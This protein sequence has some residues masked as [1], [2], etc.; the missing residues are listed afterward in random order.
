MV[1]QI[2][3]E[4]QHH[5]FKLWQA[6]DAE[7][8]LG[9]VARTDYVLARPH[10]TMFDVMGRL[11]RRGGRLVIIMRGR[12][13]IPRIHDVMGVITLDTMGEAVI[14]NARPYTQPVSRNPFP[15]LYRRRVVRPMRFWT[16]R[17]GRPTPKPNP[18]PG[19]GRE[20][21]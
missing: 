19:P 20:K 9:D 3:R 14:E 15:L 16:R 17:P 10:D 2:I 4:M 7:T 18:E 11:A 5:R 21:H 6:R 1:F 13:R 8:T 12:S